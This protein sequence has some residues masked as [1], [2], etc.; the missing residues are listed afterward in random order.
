MSG[1]WSDS[2]YI[3][4]HSFTLAGG[5]GDPCMV[6]QKTSYLE[7]LPTVHSKMS[8]PRT[9]MDLRPRDPHRRLPPFKHAVVFS[10]NAEINLYQK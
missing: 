5:A 3:S 4:S 8:T 6:T 7:H 10:G 9:G 1:S 2:E